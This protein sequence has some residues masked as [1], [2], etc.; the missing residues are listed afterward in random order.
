MN[1]GG[2]LNDDSP[3]DGAKGQD[4]VPPT[5]HQR[6]SIVNMLNGDDRAQKA[7]EEAAA[8]APESDD[9]DEQKP[10]PEL[11]ESEE[12]PAAAPAP[13]EDAKPKQASA[14]AEPALETITDELEKIKH[15][16]GKAR[17]RRYE[18]PPIWAQEWQPR[19]RYDDVPR[20][21]TGTAPGLI[22][23]EKK[24]FDYTK[25]HLVDLECLISG[26][27][28]A[29]SVL[30]TIAEWIFANFRDISEQ[31]R[32]YVELEL[33]FGTIIDKRTGIRL[34]IDVTT[35]CIYTNHL[36]IHFEMEVEEKAY[37]EVA[38]YLTELEMTHQELRDRRLRRK[39]NHLETDYTDLFFQIERAKEHPKL[40][41][42]L[43]DNTLTPRRY[44]GI[45]KQRILDLY[46]Y[47]PACMYDLRLLLLLEFP[48][49]D[50]NI[51]PIIKNNTPVLVREKK[52]LSWTH[53]ATV[54]RFDLTRVQIPKQLK[55]PLGR[56]V[57]DHD[58]HFEIEQ[59][60]DTNEVFMAM[61][62]FNLGDDAYRFEELVEI[63]LNNARVVNNRVTKLA[64]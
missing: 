22:L 25:T 58:V 15:L 28:P 43:A 63:F 21:P 20:Q 50:A 27:I 46:I 41:R 45:E 8:K 5:V 49:P 17:P 9:S 31:N 24:V 11:S 10:V 53:A 35:E 14:P 64:R 18:T 62:K 39:F 37:K 55:A 54:L 12:K 47:N 34:N 32:Q 1:L 56:R 23:L 48:V 42:V 52:R 16:K 59:E 7:K 29:P 38:L 61:D 36:G 19:L 3:P 57:V 6:H 40:V 4:A 26:V 2:L 30:R 60:I 51:E 13:T 44:T 33:K